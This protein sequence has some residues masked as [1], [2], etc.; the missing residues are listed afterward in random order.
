MPLT[1]GAKPGE[2]HTRSRKLLR[3][4]FLAEIPA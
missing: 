1:N 3:K 4:I 2:I